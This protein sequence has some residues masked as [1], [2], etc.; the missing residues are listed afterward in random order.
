MKYPKWL[1]PTIPADLT[2][3][4]RWMVALAPAWGLVGLTAWTLPDST[5]HDTIPML[6]FSFWVVLFFCL[7]L[8]PE[9]YTRLRRAGLIYCLTYIIYRLMH[10]LRWWVLG[11]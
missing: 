10:N 9:D 2:F 8:P 6:E 1:R 7:L 11:Q 3:L 5:Y 4:W